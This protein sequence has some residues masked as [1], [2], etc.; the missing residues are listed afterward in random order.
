MVSRVRVVGALSRPLSIWPHRPRHTRTIT[1]T[2]A[3]EAAAHL[4]E[5]TTNKIFTRTQLLDGNQLQKLSLTLNRKEL[6]P[7]LDITENAP[8]NGTPLPPGYHLVYFTPSQLE[9]D[10][11]PDG[12]DRTFNSPGPFTRRMWAGGRM[13]WHHDA[14]PLRVGDEVTETTQILDVSA[15]KSRDGSEMVLVDV[16][17]EYFVPGGGRALSDQR[18]WIFRKP[19]SPTHTIASATTSPPPSNIR[20]SINDTFPASPSEE[21]QEGFPTRHILLS[22]VALFRFSALTFNAHKIHYND[23]WTRQV[24][25]HPSVVVHG[26]LNLINMMDYWRDVHSHSSFSGNPPTSV[27]YRALSPVYAGDEYT[28]TTASLEAGQSGKKKTAYSKVGLVVEKRG[29]VCMRGEVFVEVKR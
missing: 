4:L 6:H 29:V 13:N 26:P 7:G 25:N 8:P 12:S 23:P 3:A 28:I 21:E 1:T 9:E 22:P 15:K 18:S 20:T 2:T 16:L 11:A 17:K 19:P 24:E 27:D 10:L 14:P 5:T